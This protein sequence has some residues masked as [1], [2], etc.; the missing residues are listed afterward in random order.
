MSMHIRIVTLG[1][2]IGL[3]SLLPARADEVSD[4]INQALTAYRRKDIP[5]AITGLE[6]AINLLRQSRADSYGALLPAAPAG[7][8]ADPVETLSVGV[9]MAGGGVGASRK[10]H[11][12]DNTV[13]VSILADS[14][15]LQV[16]SALASSGLAA[17]GGVRTQIINGHRTIYV[18]EDNAFTTIV[19][20]KILVRV[21]GVGLPE[22]TLKQF[23]TAV[24][25]AAVERTGQ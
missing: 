9:A 22:D 18:K 24:D 16:M 25:F 23:L 13:T 7:W 2:I 1:L 15:L 17:I 20:D 19:A 12:A 21:E 4:Q 3:C 5:T 11:N 10:Y 14:P 6:A 8:T